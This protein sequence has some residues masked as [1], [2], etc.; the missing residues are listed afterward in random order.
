MTES[1]SKHVKIGDWIFE[2]KMVRALKVDEYG[3]PY[4][5]IANCNINGDSMYIDG[6]LTQEGECITR[7]DLQ[8]FNDFC[9]QIGLKHCSYH[10]YQNGESITKDV[11]ITSPKEPKISKTDSRI[12]LV[13]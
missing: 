10:R 7:E 8:S 2:V 5:A 1:M 3:K 9:Y 13:K 4:S 11:S 12:H 6:L